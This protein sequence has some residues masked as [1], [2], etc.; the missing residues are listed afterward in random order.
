M[1]RPLAVIVLLLTFVLGACASGDMSSTRKRDLLLRA[2]SSAV[3]WNDFDLA[4]GYVQPALREAH[5][6]TDLEK[7]R[8]KQVQIVGYSVQEMHLAP[9]GALEQSV[10]I[11]VVNRNTQVERVIIDRQRWV[12]DDAAGRWWLVS[13][14]PNLDVR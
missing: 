7:E 8:F 1:N 2:Y 13:G 5:P 9:D 14:L 3:R 4:W 10:E 12:Y 6:L 11:R